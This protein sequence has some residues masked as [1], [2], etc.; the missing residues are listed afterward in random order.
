[1]MIHAYGVMLIAGRLSH[2]WGVSRVKE[3]FGYRVFGMA[4]TFTVIVSCAL[5]LLRDRLWA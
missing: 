1:M 2:A 5:H 3:Q 4:M